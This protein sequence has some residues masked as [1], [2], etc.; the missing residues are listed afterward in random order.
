MDIDLTN[1]IITSA[2]SIVVGFLALL[3]GRKDAGTISR[4]ELRK[5]Q[6]A[7][8]LGPLDRLLFFTDQKDPSTLLCAVVEIVETNYDLVPTRILEET[9]YLKR[10]KNLTL[11]SF[12]TLATVNASFYNWTKRALGYP[13]EATKINRFYVPHGERNSRIL[14]GSAIL[15]A[16]IYI[17]SILLVILIVFSETLNRDV[18]I[19]NWLAQIAFYIFIFGLFFT[20]ISNFHDKQI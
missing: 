19:P 2:S 6:V 15:F 5:L 1:T 13:Y 9:L 12:S 17:I 20:N 8:I 16:V 14:I 3:A 4:R 11:E 7:N 10:K 18:S